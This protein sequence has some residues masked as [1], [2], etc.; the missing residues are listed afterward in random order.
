MSN[1]QRTIASA[2]TLSGVGLH[3]G[4]TVN[5][6]ISPTESGGIVYVRTDLDGK[7]RIKADVLNV[8]DTSRGTTIGQ[9]E[10]TVSTIEH[11][12]AALYVSGITQAEIEIDGPEAPILDGSSQ[13]ILE[14]IAMAGVRELEQERE[15]L[16]FTEN[17]SFS[18]EK[19]GASYLIVPAE[20]PSYTVMIDYG[21]KVLPPQHAVLKDIGDFESEISAARTFSFLHELEFLLSKGLIKG[22]SLDNAVVFV[23]KPLGDEHR[24]RLAKLFD[25]PEV[26]VT[27]AGVLNNTDLRFT[28]EPARHKLLDMIGDLAL[29]GADIKGHIIATKPGHGGNAALG[30]ALT[31]L[32]KESRKPQA[33]RIDLNAEPLFD[34]NGIMAKLPH[35]PPF[36]FVDKIFELTDTHVVGIKNVSMNEPFFVGHFPGA[37][38]MPGV[39]QIEAMA[40]VG[41][42]LVLSTVPD[43]E[44][45]LTYFLKMD[46]V[47]FRKMVMPGD[48]II[49]RMDLVSP[50]RR[51]LCHMQGYAYVNN[52]LVMEA[53]LMAQIQ[54]RKDTQSAK[55]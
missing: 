55:E 13:P 53:E 35:R 23:E 4:K 32:L 45:W 43:P 29:L 41:G 1:K 3:T 34:I 21:S 11:V 39:L 12:M 49:F 2:A 36:L 54:R 24:E 44:N 8:V 6:T 28:N 14:V 22:G 38:V 37:P 33:P 20:K 52:E 51:G 40:Q 25:K 47:K 5:L 26:H 9:G 10:A 27:Q 18:D 17:Y 31:G 46:N 16:Q 42:I 7:P 48:T 30:K 50:I 15:S 19:S